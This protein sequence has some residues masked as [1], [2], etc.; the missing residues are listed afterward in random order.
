M[1]RKTISTL[2]LIVLQLILVNISLAAVV[3]LESPDGKIPFT[4]GTDS[5]NH[6]VYW[7]QFNGKVVISESRIGIGVGN[8]RLGDGNGFD[9]ADWVNCGFVKL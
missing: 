3:D 6:L 2:L 5:T 9:H 8:I 7:V 1:R 4:A